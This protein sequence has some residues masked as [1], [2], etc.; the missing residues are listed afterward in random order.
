MINL[1]PP[2]AEKRVISFGLYGANPKYVVGAIHNVEAG[3]I[4]FPGWVC[5]FY[6]TND[7]PLDAIDTLKQMG[8]EVEAIPPGMGYSSGM[9]WRFLVAADPTVDRYIVRDAD[10]RLNARDRIAVEEWVRVSAPFM[11]FHAPSCTFNPLFTLL[12]GVA[13]PGAYPTRPRE[14]LPC[15]ERRHVGGREGGD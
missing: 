13:L 11:H 12:G 3:R 10:S 14:P 6:V 5:R 15:H 4:Y 9:F 2:S 8:A 1:I 7:V